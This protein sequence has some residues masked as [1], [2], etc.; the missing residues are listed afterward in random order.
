MKT[1][2]ATAAALLALAAPAQAQFNF[3]LVNDIQSA[4]SE[5]ISW[6]QAGNADNACKAVIKA[7]AL[8]TKL[9]DGIAMEAAV[10]AQVASMR[11]FTQHMGV[12]CAFA[13]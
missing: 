12:Y 10:K 8:A 3:Y 4:T 1:L 13:Y 6:V 7:E 5:V 2:F 9:D 11:T